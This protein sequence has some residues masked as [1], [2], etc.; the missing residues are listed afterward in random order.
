MAE[1]KPRI[2]IGL[3]YYLVHTSWFPGYSWTIT[4]CSI[5]HEHL[6]WKFQLVPDRSGSRATGQANRPQLFWGLSG[7][8]VTTEPIP[9]ERVDRGRV[10]LDWLLANV[11]D[12]D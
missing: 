10:R 1:Q 9:S 12:H 3:F 4:Y 8:S 5:C 2:V 6:G 11:G 7:S